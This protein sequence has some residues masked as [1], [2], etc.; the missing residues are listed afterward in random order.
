M[1]VRRARPEDAPRLAVLAQ[2]VWIDSYA[3]DG[4]EAAFVP[5][6]S[7]SFSVE[8]FERVLADPAR[9]L[10]V[11]ETGA[12]LQGLA[13]L[14]HA[15]PA[16]VAGH[17]RFRVELE[18]LYVVPRQTGRG[19]GAELLALARTT[20]P[21]QGLWLSVWAGNTGAQRFYGREGGEVIGE[22]DFMLDGQAH[23]N[24][25]YGWAAP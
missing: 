1:T 23:R 13:Q 19:L 12:A 7:D 3:A 14:R 5:Y 11:H 8:A 10:W 17:E 9:V 4:V 20:W 22:T 16:P 6:L 15:A 24:L 18:R 21:D 2:W 25:V